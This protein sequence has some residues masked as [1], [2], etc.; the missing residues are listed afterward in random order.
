MQMTCIST[1]LC[2]LITQGPI[3]TLYNFILDIGLFMAANFLQFSQD[4]TEVLVID[5][6]ALRKKLNFKL[7]AVALKPSE[8]V[9]NQGIIFDSNFTFE[10]HIRHKT[11][12]GFYHLKKTQYVPFSP[13]LTQ[14]HYFITCRID[15]CN[16]LLPGL[17][18]RKIAPLQ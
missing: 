9:K 13:K 7:T 10:H 3:D 1:L 11:K 15:Y 5:P 16:A 4:K 6:E 14:R 12:N 8:T 18:T 17:P 2:P